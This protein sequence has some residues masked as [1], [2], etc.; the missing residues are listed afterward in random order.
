MLTSPTNI[1]TLS[2]HDALPIFCDRTDPESVRRG[3]RFLLGS[4][5]LA[6]ANGAA[7]N[8]VAVFGDGQASHR[9]I[10][11]GEP[12]KKLVE[13]SEEHTSELQSHHDIVCRLI[14]EI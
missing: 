7:V 3:Q 11:F 1:H 9:L 5:D 10:L 8:N 12:V 2:L 4:V 13:R 14:L 6:V